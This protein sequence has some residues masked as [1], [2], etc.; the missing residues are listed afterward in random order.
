MHRDILKSL[1]QA[2]RCKQHGLLCQD[3]TI[4]HNI[5]MLHIPYETSTSYD[6]MPQRIQTTIPKILFS[7]PAISISFNPL[8]S[9]C[10]TNDMQQKQFATGY[11]VFYNV[12][13]FITSKIFNLAT[14]ISTDGFPV[15]I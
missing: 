13:C 9:I 10:S 6:V 12:G 3:I 15:C 1:Q 2:V 7:C 8:T 5:V 14:L 11:D 4:L